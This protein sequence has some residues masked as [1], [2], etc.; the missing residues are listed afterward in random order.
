MD[1]T[2][3]ATREGWL[4]LAVVI[5]LYSRMV[6]GWS[7]DKRMTKELVINALNVAIKR[8]N[9][10]PGLICHLSLIHI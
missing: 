5:D 7:I 4:Y 10:S 6:V 9:P 3:I 1:I 2:Y 8:R